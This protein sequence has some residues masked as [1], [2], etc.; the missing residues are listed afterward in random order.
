MS[1][2]HHMPED[3]NLQKV[4]VFQEIGVFEDGGIIDGV[5]Y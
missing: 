1:I 5:I 3:G 4:D 2:G